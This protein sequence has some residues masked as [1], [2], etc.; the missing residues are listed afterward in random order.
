[1]A[2]AGASAGAGAG[3]CGR[4]REERRCGMGKRAGSWRYSS[5]RSISLQF[6]RMHDV[7]DR[8]ISCG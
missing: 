5:S 4:Q 6:A 2:W 7:I 8:F 3:T 1:V